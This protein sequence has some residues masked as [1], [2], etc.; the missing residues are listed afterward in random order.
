MRPGID[1]GA[2]AVDYRGGMRFARLLRRPLIGDALLAL[3]LVVLG[4][5]EIWVP[6]SSGIGH[7][8]GGATS[9][10]VVIAGGSLAL[11]RR[12]PLAS[13]AV[14]FAVWPLATLAAS[15]QILFWGGF[16]PFLVAVYSVARYGGEKRGVYGGLLGLAALLSLD[17]L[18]AELREPGELAFDWL[19][20]ACAW[21]LGRA[22]YVRQVRGE[23]LARQAL[24]LQRESEARAREAVAAERGRIA[25]ELHDVVAHSVSVMVV[26]AGAAEEIVEDDPKLVRETLQAIRETGSEALAEMRR[27]IGV[28]RRDGDELALAPQPGLARLGAIVEQARATGL[29]VSLRIEGQARPLPPGLDLAAYRIVQEALTNTRKHADA[30]AADVRIRYAAEAL[31]LEIVDDGRGGSPDKSGG[32]HGLVGMRERVSLYGGRLEAGPRVDGG[33]RVHAELP[34]G[35]A[36]S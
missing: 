5:L 22:V 20:F 30:R 36:R 27:L 9:A 32:G 24:D 10:V 25:R 8:S 28:V 31:E 29:E 2:C 35:A 13:A 26:Q 6:F 11:R 19:G 12:A 34:L 21:G 1:E 23:T 7:S 15:I 16:V 4:L 14:F 18:V 17:L 33:F 3:S